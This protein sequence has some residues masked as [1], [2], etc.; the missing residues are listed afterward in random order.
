MEG[1]EIRQ[2]RARAIRFHG[3]TW[4]VTARTIGV[5]SLIHYQLEPWNPDD[6]EINGTEIDYTP[7]YV[8]AR[9]RTAAVSRRRERLSWPLRPFSPL[10]GF[11]P[12]RTK[13]HL[14]IVYGIDPVECT[15]H[16]I[17]VEFLISINALV[18][19]AIGMGAWMKGASPA[20]TGLPV[21]VFV[22]IA[23]IVG[24]DGA[25]R[26]GRILAEERPPPGFYEW[27]WRGR[28]NLN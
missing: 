22:L 25:T 28:I 18:L 5:D 6:Y 14:E 24:I 26:Y 11:L 12:A 9:D 3:R 16:S 2:H 23:V 7:A 4:R 10:I 27:L 21:N 17:F 19:A 20:Q 15:R 13:A 8:A 1:W